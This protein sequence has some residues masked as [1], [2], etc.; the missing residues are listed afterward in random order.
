MKIEMLIYQ[1]F[2]VAMACK[3][4]FGLVI[5]GMICIAIVNVGVLALTTVYCGWKVGAIVL[6]A[7]VA[8]IACQQ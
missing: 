7:E 2:C 1:S 8:L 6:G 3:G 4:I 5:G